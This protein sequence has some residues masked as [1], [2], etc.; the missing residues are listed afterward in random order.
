MST[1]KTVPT[2]SFTATPSAITYKLKAGKCVFITTMVNIRKYATMARM[3]PNAY[4]EYCAKSSA[5]QDQFMYDLALE[6]SYDEQQLDRA[7]N[8]PDDAPFS[9]TTVWTQADIDEVAGITHCD[10][11]GVQPVFAE[12]SAYLMSLANGAH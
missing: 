10:E 11:D 12:P 3:S 9:L 7:I 1:I 4:L 2:R 8:A 5:F 6:L